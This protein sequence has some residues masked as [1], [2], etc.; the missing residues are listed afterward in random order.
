MQIDLSVLLPC[1]TD[2]A[3]EYARQ[4]RLLAH[5]AHPLIDFK[6]VGLPEFPPLWKKG[7][8][9]V[10]MR[11]FGVFPLGNQAVV[12]TYPQH[13]EG[14]AMRDNGHSHLIG[15]WDHLITIEKTHAGTLYR[16][17]L[18]VQAGFTTPMIWLFAK[19]FF[20]HRQRRWVQLAKNG[21]AF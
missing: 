9:W 13:R 5:V 11:L 16:D 19:I 10:N 2:V 14:F 17:R 4:P 15:T 21:F 20:R 3:V 7:K 1:T 6:P 18:V 12:I 8:N